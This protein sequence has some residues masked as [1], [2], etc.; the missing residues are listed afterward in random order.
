MMIVMM[1]SITTVMRMT[2]NSIIYLIA[3]ELPC[4]LSE[5][6]WRMFGDS[7]IAMVVFPVTWASEIII[8]LMALCAIIDSIG[9]ALDGED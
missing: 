4:K 2:N 3:W 5:V 9:R 8:L 7:D 6:L 1:T